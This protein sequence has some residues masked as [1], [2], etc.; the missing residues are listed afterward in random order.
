MR[1]VYS[2]GRPGPMLSMRSWM[3]TDLSRMVPCGTVPAVVIDFPPLSGVYMEELQPDLLDSWKYTNTH[4]GTLKTQLESQKIG[5]L[6]FEIFTA[7]GVRGH[8]ASFLRELRKLCSKLR[9]LLVLDDTMMSMRC[10]ALFSYLLYKDLCVP[11]YII[12]GKP[13]LSSM[14]ITTHTQ[15]VTPHPHRTA[16][17]VYPAMRKTLHLDRKSTRLNSSHSSVSR[18]PSS[19]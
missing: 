16:G 8:T 19:A 9:V 14:L 11:D 6:M 17:T 1:G 15:G 18:M 10:G 12:V 2:S 3:H 13:W 7:D 5:V 4:I